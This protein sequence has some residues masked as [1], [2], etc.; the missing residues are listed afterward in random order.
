M[1]KVRNLLLILVS[2]RLCP[3]TPFGNCNNVL[4]WIHLCYMHALNMCFTF[5][6]VCAFCVWIWRD[7]MVSSTCQLLRVKRSYMV[8]AQAIVYGYDSI[9]CDIDFFYIKKYDV[10]FLHKGTKTF[11]L[12][13]EGVLLKTK[14][15]KTKYQCTWQVC[16]AIF[17]LY[18]KQKYFY[19]VFFTRVSQI[20]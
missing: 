17:C 3:G 13:K 11:F 19:M 4:Y 7:S 12:K 1:R 5:S 6:F 8:C 20:F 10:T 2:L 15:S 14:M 16:S 9:T 18:F